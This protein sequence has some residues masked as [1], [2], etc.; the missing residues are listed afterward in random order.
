M[1]EVIFYEDANGNKPVAEF[2][3]DLRNKSST[4]KDA[5][6]NFKK[7]VAYIDLL[8]EH[9]SIIGMPVVKHLDGDIWELRPI[10]NR[11]LYAYYKDNKYILLHHFKKASR[12]LPPWELEQ[13]KRNL[14][15]YIK[16]EGK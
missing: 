2:I 15:D 13:A 1:Y 9:G 4:N 3:N 7:V 16:R 10:K 5:R 8:E 14:E 11:I 12:K 6:I